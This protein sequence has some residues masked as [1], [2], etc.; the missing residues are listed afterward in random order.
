ME[1][2]LVKLLCDF[3]LVVLIWMVQLLIYPSFKHMSS[4]SLLAWHD[5]YSKGISI[6][7]VPLM[8]GQLLLSGLLLMREISTYRAFD[9]FLVVTV[10]VVTFGIFVPIHSAI[11][12]NRFSRQL[13]QGLVIK[14]WM[15][16][17]I[18]TG[19][20]LLNLYMVLR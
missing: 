19:I 2:S 9:V 16:T 3:G 13:L 7:V 5:E 6:I 18:W 8:L 20:F 1:L 12:N 15:R 11:A 4:E 10:W 14:N 17:I